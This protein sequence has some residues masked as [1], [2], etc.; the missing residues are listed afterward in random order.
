[1]R[2]LSTVPNTLRLR[3]I[4]TAV[5][6]ATLYVS[7]ADRIMAR[8]YEPDDE[9]SFHQLP[10]GGGVI[11]EV[12]RRGL[13][14]IGLGLFEPWVMCDVNGD[15]IGYEIDV[16]REMAEDWG[17]LIQFVRTDWYF[18][19]PALIEKEFDLIVSGMGI[20][21]ERSL[22]VNFSIPYAE[23][24]TAVLA[25]T[26]RTDGLTEQSDFNTPDI[27]FGARSGTVPEQTVTDH[28]PS[29]VLRSFDSDT[30]L[31][32][33]LLAGEVHAVAVDQVKATRWLESHA[34]S[35][36]RPFDDLFNKIPEAV[37]LR[38]GDVDG[39]NVVNSWIT[40][41]QTTGWLGERRHYWF[42]TRDWADRVATDPEVI[43]GCDASFEA[44][45]Y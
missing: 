19:V 22:R 11:E 38:K 2:L 21:P 17:V 4:G 10:T 34:D 1:M 30:E 14:K 8:G 42:E 45:P 3:W 36:H 18:I 7:T 5:L 28:F 31:L 27:V 43:Q 32:G 15:L 26:L 39:L 29:A 40:H 9:S 25:N 44:N 35:V 23:F 33:V 37:A 12:Q 41:H 13:L 6:L 16:A 20:T 24:G